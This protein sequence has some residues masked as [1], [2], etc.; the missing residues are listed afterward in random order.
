MKSLSYIRLLIDLT[1][2]QKN[3]KKDKKEIT[4]FY[5]FQAAQLLYQVF[6][7]FYWICLTLQE[8]NEQKSKLQRSNQTTK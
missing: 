4:L 7:P 5:P 8:E 1:K 3:E 2:K 6:V